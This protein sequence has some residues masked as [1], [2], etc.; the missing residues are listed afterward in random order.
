[1][2]EFLDELM[3]KMYLRYGLTPY[4]DASGRVIKIISQDFEKL[5]EDATRYSTDNV[6]IEDWQAVVEAF[7]TTFGRL[8]SAA[9]HYSISAKILLKSLNK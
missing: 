2:E 6:T 9:H 1:M 3:H 8:L 5:K 4:G 7:S